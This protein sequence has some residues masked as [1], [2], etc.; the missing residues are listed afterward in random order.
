MLAVV[1]E[2]S[3]WNLCSIQT[4][5]FQYKHFICLNN[6]SDC[7][8]LCGSTATEVAE[9]Y[10]CVLVGSCDHS[11]YIRYIQ[12][13]ELTLCIDMS[14]ITFTRFSHCDDVIL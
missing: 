12:V 1:H 6:L 3:L 14:C 8:A 2:M 10:F 4:Y 11:C 13:G 9:K 5:T 7:L